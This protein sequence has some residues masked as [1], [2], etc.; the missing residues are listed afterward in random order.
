MMESGKS[1]MIHALEF[2]CEAPLRFYEH[3]S[4]CPQFSSNCTD[5]RLGKEILRAK[6]K[7]NYS[8]KDY[9]EGIVHAS[10][11][12]CTAPL[13]YFEKSRKK[14]GH[15]GRCREE[16]LLLSLLSG[17]KALDYSQK[18][19]VDLPTVRR[20]REDRRTKEIE[21]EAISS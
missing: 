1:R 8:G 10:S 2:G 4:A 13:Q 5:L 17:K 20:R 19:A 9:V 16:G 6:K 21:A 7:L 15:E 12:N 3:C 11:F 14:C 18:T